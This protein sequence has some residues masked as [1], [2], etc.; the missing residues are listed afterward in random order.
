MKDLKFNEMETL[1]RSVSHELEFIGKCL[2]VRAGGRKILAVGDLH[3]GYEESL[4]RSGVFVSRQMFGE[5]KKYFESVFLRIGEVV[6]EVVLL[7]D[8]KHDFGRIIFQERNDF[9]E[10]VNFLG[11]FCKR[12][13]V[14]KGNH[15]KILEPMARNENVELKESYVV[16]KFCFMHGDEEKVEGEEKRVKFWVL[17]HGHPAVKISDGVKVEKY[18]CFLVGS[19]KRKKVVIVPSFFEGGAGSDPRENDLGMGWNFNFDK[20]DV[21]I[22]QDEGLRVLEFGKLGK[23]G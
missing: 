19:W 9:A 23:L 6:D 5:V 3:L 2:L 4:N 22:V 7:G 17:G 15:D 18:K 20:F 8:V 21:L 12:I 13:V 14:V 10:L 16:G 1:G 11:S